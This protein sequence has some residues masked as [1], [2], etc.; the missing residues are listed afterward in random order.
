MHSAPPAQRQFFFRHLGEFHNLQSIF[1]RLNTTY[2]R[3]SPLRRYKIT[4]GRR[5]RQLPKEYFVFGTIQEQERVIRIHPLLDAPWVPRWFLEF[6]VY[7]EMLHSVVPD[8][9]LGLGGRR[10]V[11]TEEFQRREKRF[12]HYRRAR[13]WEKANLERFLR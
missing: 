4:W 8:E 6:V 12:A 2:F 1:N 13:R 10:R 7:H 5:R 3:G 9:P 11:H